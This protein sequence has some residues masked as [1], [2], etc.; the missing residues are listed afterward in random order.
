MLGIDEVGVG[1]GASGL[2]AWG[3][4]VGARASSITVVLSTPGAAETLLLL[5]GE[6]RF[7]VL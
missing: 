6:V 5:G 1:A 7:G 4:F 3:G 2:G